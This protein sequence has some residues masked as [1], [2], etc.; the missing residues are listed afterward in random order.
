MFF[1]SGHFYVPRKR[2]YCS[3]KTRPGNQYCGEHLPDDQRDGNENTRRVPCPFDPNHTVAI[4]DLVSH[5]ARCNSRPLPPPV[6]HSLN[7]NVTLPLSPEE[8]AFQQNIFS[9]KELKSQP[10]I[11][12]VQLDQLP[13]GELQALLQ[14]IQ[15]TASSLL[16]SIPTQILSHPSLVSDATSLKTCRHLD[17]QS[18][19]IGHMKE[20][21][22]LDHK[23]TCY[24]EFGAGKGRE[25]A[26]HVKNALTEENGRPTFVLVDRK[27]VRNKFDKVLLGTSGAD[28]E[29]QRVLIDIKDLDFSKIPS[30]KDQ[31]D[32]TKKI[33][34]ISKHL[35]GSATDITLKCLMNYVQQEKNAGQPSSIQGI[36]IALCCHQLCRYEMYPN[37][38]YLD[39]LGLDKQDFDRLCKVSSWAVCGKR[40]TD[41]GHPQ[42]KEDAVDA[43]A[44]HYSGCTHQQREQLGYQCKRLL[45]MGRVNYL[46]QHGF[47]ARLVYYADA[48]DT[49]ENCALIAIP[50]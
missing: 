43:Q 27:S 11:A 23:D 33:V 25:L 47:D 42:A 14:K 16:P 1:S 20:N 31:H 7:L 40:S 18:S 15:H 36:V 44:N 24:A 5:K 19:L 29:V 9:H 28:S 6:Y 10:W 30:I 39:Q 22:M 21:G 35:C 2:K 37:T 17:Q 46:K 12:R 49:L 32:H 4:K 38:A 13:D 3:L 41:D 26:H 48:T 8:L 45:D 34:C 50:R